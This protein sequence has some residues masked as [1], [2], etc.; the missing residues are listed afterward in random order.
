LLSVPALGIPAAQAQLARSFVSAATGNDANDCNRA[1]P[2]RTFQRAHDN[3]FDQGEVTVLDTGGYGA[4]TIT[5][6]ISIVSQ[7]GEASILV[8]GG[9]TGITIDAP[10]G[11]YVSLRGLTVQGIGFG[12]GRGLVFNSGFAL[13]ITHCVIRN[14]TS[15][16]IGFIPTT[17]AQLAVFDTLIADNGGFGIAGGGISGPVKIDLDHVQVANNS[18]AGIQL[19]GAPG[20]LHASIADSVF[21]GNGEGVRADGSS[22][23]PSTAVVVRSVLSNNRDAAAMAVGNAFIGIGQSMIS[24]NADTWFTGSGGTLWSF[25][26]NYVLGNFDGDRLMSVIARK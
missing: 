23:Q 19:F 1:T 16:G 17:S 5:K 2:C 3:T 8:S 25:G 13:T 18:L 26:D 6:S 11:G 12:G 4:V 7:V 20:G 14:L 21:S 15:D 10:A 22:G 9:N 24:G